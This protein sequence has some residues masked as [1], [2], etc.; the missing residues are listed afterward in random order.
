[1]SGRDKNV[2]RNTERCGEKENGKEKQKQKE[3]EGERYHSIVSLAATVSLR[4]S[5]SMLV[6]ALVYK[7]LALT[8]HQS[9][10]F[11]RMRVCQASTPARDGGASSASCVDSLLSFCFV[12]VY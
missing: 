12:C 8:S 10:L 7:F 5:L 9:T 1:M 3:E 11:L 6:T 2:N 4:F